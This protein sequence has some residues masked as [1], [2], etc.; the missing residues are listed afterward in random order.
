MTSPLRSRGRFSKHMKASALSG[1]LGGVHTVRKIVH[2][3][4]P[5]LDPGVGALQAILK[6]VTDADPSR[7]ADQAG[8]LVLPFD[9]GAATTFRIH[10]VH[11]AA[12]VKRRR[13]AMVGLGHVIDEEKK[14][15]GQKQSNVALTLNNKSRKSWQTTIT[16]AAEDYITVGNAYLEVV[17]PSGSG[18][19]ISGIHYV[20]AC[21]VRI[22]LEDDRG[23]NRHFRVLNGSSRASTG[24]RATD[25][26]DLIMAEFGD[27]AD[28][29][30]R[31]KEPLPGLTRLERERGGFS[32]LIHIPQPTA[33]QDRWYGFP[34]WLAATG[35][36]ELTQAALQSQF[37]LFSNRGVPEFLLFLLGSKVN[38][39]TWDEMSTVFDG[40]VGLGNQHQSSMFNLPDPDIKVQVERLALEGIANGTFFKDMMEVLSTTIVSAHGVPPNLAGIVLPGKIAAANEISASVMGFQTLVVGPAQ[41]HFQEILGCAL[42]NPL[43]NQGLEIPAAPADSKE[44]S[45]D[46]GRRLQFADFEFNTIVAAMGLAMETLRPVDSMERMRDEAPEAAARGRDPGAGTLR[47][48]RSDTQDV[49]QSMDYRV[50]KL[51]EDKDLMAAVFAAAAEAQAKRNGHG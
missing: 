51:F 47:D 31:A 3:L 50:R 8:E 17:R 15:A 1:S 23:I 10:N 29:E 33:G 44:L 20:P 45:P 34:D 32:E 2:D 5:K 46:A 19:P 42:G 43:F 27:L 6:S 13:E 11:H 38:D 39:K 26:G 21:N 24:G 14:E 36:V 18:S 28:L 48:G 12:C 37:D 40:Y 9:F 49:T 25:R 41:V 22:V 4:W 35:Y 7:Q 16:Q 30:R